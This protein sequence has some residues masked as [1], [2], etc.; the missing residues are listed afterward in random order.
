M[1]IGSL[2]LGREGLS[3]YRYCLEDNVFYD[4]NRFEI[5]GKYSETTLTTSKEYPFLLK[6][7]DSKGL[8]SV[9]NGNYYLGRIFNSGANPSGSYYSLSDGTKILQRR[10]EVIEKYREGGI[11][12]FKI[13]DKVKVISSN[14]IEYS[15]GAIGEI[16]NTYP[17]SVAKIYYKIKFTEGEFKTLWGGLIWNVP[18]DSLELYVDL[19]HLKLYN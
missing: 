5:V 11:R 8:S 2:Y 13:G 10:F 16:V 17:D 14:T 1:V 15:V 3:I 18:E 4:R 12:K 9:E 19:P 6:C 7:I